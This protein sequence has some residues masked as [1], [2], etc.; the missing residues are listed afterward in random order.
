MGWLGLGEAFCFTYIIKWATIVQLIVLVLRTRSLS[1]HVLIMESTIPD[2][3]FHGSWNNARTLSV[4]NNAPIGGGVNQ[5]S[6]SLDELLVERAK[7]GDVEAFET[8][9]ASHEK[10]VF[11]YAY[12]LTGNYEDAGDIAQ[13]AFLRVYNSLPEFR[14]DSSFT[15]WLYRIVRNACL[16][17]MRKR[18][19]QRVTSLDETLEMDDGEM[20]RQ[21]ADSTD[22][23]EQA[24]ERVEVQRAVLDSINSLDD[25]YRVVVVL[26]DIEGYSY[27]EIADALGINLG[28]VKSRLNRARGALKEAFAKL[29]LLAPK[30]VY[31]GR[32]GKAH[33]L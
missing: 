18:K 32:R 21:F 27:N 8:L 23:P 31:S 22:G 15:T 24:L 28:T 5:V 20:S 9:V 11:N 14:G 26:R 7:R 4:C 1:V 2:K 13:E 33:E 3:I 25:E 16:D 29:E 6:K 17:E 30:V 19:R 12:R 10:A